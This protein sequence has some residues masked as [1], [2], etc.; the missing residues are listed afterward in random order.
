M[1]KLLVVMP[2]YNDELYVERAINSILNQTFKNLMVEL[3]ASKN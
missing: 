2:L 3:K 1:K